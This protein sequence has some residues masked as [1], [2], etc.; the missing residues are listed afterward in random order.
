[1]AELVS[2]REHRLVGAR[3]AGERGL[4]RWAARFQRSARRAGAVAS[5]RGQV[6]QPTEPWEQAGPT[7]CSTSEGIQRRRRD[8]GRHLVAG[9]L[10]LSSI[11]T[12]I[13]ERRPPRPPGSWRAMRRR[14]NVWKRAVSAVIGGG[15]LGV[16]S[17]V[18]AE[19]VLAEGPG[20]LVEAAG[21]GLELVGGLVE[22]AA[23]SRSV[24]TWCRSSSTC[25]NR[26]PHLVDGQQRGAAWLNSAPMRMISCSGVTRSATSAGGIFRSWRSMA[27]RELDGRR[28]QQ[29]LG[30]CATLAGRG[31]RGRGGARAGRRGR[32]A[33]VQ[34]E[35]S[36][37]GREPGRPVPRLPCTSWPAPTP[38]TWISRARGGW[39]WRRRRR[40]TGRPAGRSRLS[41]WSFKYS[42]TRKGRQPTW[43]RRGER[44]LPPSAAPGA[45]FAARSR[46]RGLDATGGIEILERQGGLTRPDRRNWAP[47]G[48]EQPDEPGP[49]CCLGEAA[50]RGCGTHGS[51]RP[52]CS[53]PAARA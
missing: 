34:D 12:T 32:A 21:D 3:R 47:C 17:G 35:D 20:R 30:A 23:S 41:R 25:A 42:L 8:P 46:S 2:P 33:G 31:R 26:V 10:V 13:R 7:P 49:A 29:R 39:R 53:M 22:L 52:P 38:A 50:G 27:R 40:R 6:K 16:E 9:A 1:M 36:G 11:I 4:A 18:G 14:S 37:G 43:R 24:L 19:R 28:R 51:S 15:H 5:F 45:P 44:L 48:Q